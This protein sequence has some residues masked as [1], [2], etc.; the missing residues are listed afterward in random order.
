MREH[1]RGGG[2]KLEEEHVS[3]SG[4]MSGTEGTCA[5]TARARAR[6]EGTI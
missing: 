2:D 1:N 4:D 6:E 5:K 3:E